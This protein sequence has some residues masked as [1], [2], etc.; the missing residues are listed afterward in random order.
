MSLLLMRLI[1]HFCCPLWRRYRLQSYPAVIR[2]KRNNPT[3]LLTWWMWQKKLNCMGIASV[4]LLKHGL[5]QKVNRSVHITSLGH[6]LLGNNSCSMPSIWHWYTWSKTKKYEAKIWRQD[7]WESYYPFIIASILTIFT[8]IAKA[9]RQTS[10]AQDL[11]TRAFDCCYWQH[12]YSATIQKSF[13]HCCKEDFLHTL[14]TSSGSVKSSE[15]DLSLTTQVSTEVIYHML[16][17]DHLKY[18][19]HIREFLIVLGFFW[20]HML[21]LFTAR[22]LI[23][24]DTTWVSNQPSVG[25]DTLLVWLNNSPI[26]LW[27]F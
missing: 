18:Q 12:H 20:F 16:Q 6:W 8:H 27:M 17:T 25:S 4:E 3:R 10:T 21:F 23:T 1:Q 9:D 19:D 14:L 24:I 7:Y 26:I 22:L 13:I 2:M 11:N 5:L 15:F